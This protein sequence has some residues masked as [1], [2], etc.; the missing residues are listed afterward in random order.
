MYCMPIVIKMVCFSFP[1]PAHEE[2]AG[3][4]MKKKQPL[5]REYLDGFARDDLKRIS[6][7]HSSN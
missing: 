2:P 3:G 7:I 1:I 5:S 4:T 6:I